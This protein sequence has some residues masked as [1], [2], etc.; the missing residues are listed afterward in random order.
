MKQRKHFLLMAIKQPMPN[1]FRGTS[2]N[3][4]KLESYAENKAKSSNLFFYL[5]SITDRK[6]QINRYKDQGSLVPVSSTIADFEIFAP[7]GNRFNPLHLNLSPEDESCKNARLTLYRYLANA[8][9][10]SSAN[11]MQN[12]YTLMK[13]KDI[14]QKT[15]KWD[16]SMPQSKVDYGKFS[17][18]F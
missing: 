2:F 7:E 13:E 15:L 6:E 14:D 4:H 16:A 5:P 9:K 10:V 8:C 1:M 11:L 12:V 3:S 17:T 18:G